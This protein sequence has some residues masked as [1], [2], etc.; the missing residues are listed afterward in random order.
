M[1]AALNDKLV[2]EMFGDKEARWF[3]LA[4]RNQ[5]H[6]AL[7]E[8]YTRICIIQPT[9]TGKTI[10][11]G[12]ILIDEGIRETLGVGENEDL[13]VLFV[14]HRKRLL[15]QAEKTY[16]DCERLKV[17]THSMMS[18]LPIGIKFHVVIIDECHHEA[19][20]SFQHQLES[21]SVVPIIGLTA[22]P[23][24]NDGRLCKFDKFI[25]P[26]TR[27]EAVNQGFLAEADVFTFV[28]SPTKTHVE[29]SLDIIKNHHQ[30]MG[31]QMVF[32]KTKEEAEEMLRGIEALGLTGSLLVDI[33]EREL[34]KQLDE[35]EQKKH[36]FSI[37]CMKLGEGVDVKG[38]EGILI[39]R[40]LKSR[41]LL[42]QLIGRAA[43]L[44][45]DCRVYEIINP[46]ANDNISA[47]DIVGVPRS[48]KFFYKVRGEWREHALT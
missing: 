2:T 33:S 32:C 12:L 34:N 23:D 17:I 16:A 18:P 40:T 39:A 45:S 3:Q 29:I 41:G 13:I 26:L 46:L 24:R 47:V 44:G 35:F 9:G 43:R 42:N 1:T 10:S 38:C 36:Q 30:V 7:I 22:T 5:T 19:T 15:S 8:G 14:S 21:I 6:A 27:E 11:S 37:S 31:Q 28:D 48:H 20:L 25:E 4:V